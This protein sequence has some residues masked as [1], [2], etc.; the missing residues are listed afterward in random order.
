MDVSIILWSMAVK[1]VMCM[2]SHDLTNFENY[3]RD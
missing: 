1:K 2:F 3:A